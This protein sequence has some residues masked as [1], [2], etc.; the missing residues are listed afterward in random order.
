MLAKLFAPLE[1]RIAAAIIAVLLALLGC[2]LFNTY[3]D[4]SLN[5]PFGIGFH[6]EGWKP[7]ALRDEL[8]LAA[9]KKAQV[10]ALERA[11]AAKFKAENKY[12]NLADRIDLN[13]QNA[14]VD[15]LADA[16]RYIAAHRVRCEAS[17]GAGSGTVAA[18]DR[19]GAGRGEAA[20]P[21][22]VVDAAV[23]VS[24]DDV[25]ICTANT[26]RLEAARDWALGLENAQ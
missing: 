7:R 3:A 22:P 9:V 21:A 18:S 12:R 15:A 13:A 19:G 11:E 2:S 6:F 16:E 1:M 23:A 25:R 10:V 17:G 20:S 5:G 24:A 8:D 26:V 4:V 14:R